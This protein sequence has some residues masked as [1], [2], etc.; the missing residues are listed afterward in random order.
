MHIAY[1]LMHLIESCGSSKQVGPFQ[2]TLAE[3]GCSLPK[4]DHI[5]I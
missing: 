1:K 4:K 2:M 5:K 3:V